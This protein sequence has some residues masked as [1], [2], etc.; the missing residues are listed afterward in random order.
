LIWLARLDREIDNLRAALGWLLEHDLDAAHR[1]AAALAEYWLARGQ[2][3]EG[4]QWLS[5]AL[6]HG[7]GVSA[8][9]RARTLCEAGKLAR[10]Q[11]DFDAAERLL[12]ESLTL[13]EAVGDQRGIADALAGLGFAA[14]SAER[15]DRA[16]E[17]LTRSLEIFRALG[18]RWRIGHLVAGMAEPAFQRG[19]EAEGIAL[20]HEALTIAREQHDSISEAITMADLGYR[21][22]GFH[23]QELRDADQASHWFVESLALFRDHGNM[24]GIAFAMEGVAATWHAQ[25]HVRRAAQLF[26][27]AAALRTRI[28][29]PVVQPD[30]SHYDRHV[31]ALRA[32]LGPEAFDAAWSDGHTLT[33]EA[34]ISIALQPH[35]DAEAKP[36]TPTAVRH[37]G[38]SPRELE[39]LRLLAAGQSN[40]EIAAA[41]FISYHTVTRHVTNILTKLGLDS[42]TAA[43]AWAVRHGFSV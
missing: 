27:A 40:Q 19:A 36:V 29:F 1:C 39:V 13:F 17:L 26:G 15:Y 10:W 3:S 42:R 34:A 23:R 38:L 11:Q 43:A 35:G 4:R 33:T 22:L 41:L 8:T 7:S 5:A 25:Q 2:M 14:G 18:D 31:A 9:T 20:L 32:A 37:S 30:R 24:T 28:G 21:T 12:D 16:H 6:E